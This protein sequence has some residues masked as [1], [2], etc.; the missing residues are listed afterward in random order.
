MPGWSHRP[1]FRNPTNMT[2]G[3]SVGMPKGIAGY[4]TGGIADEKASVA[5]DGSPRDFSRDLRP[6]D[7]SPQSAYENAIQSSAASFA[8]GGKDSLNR[9]ENKE[10][11]TLA[12]NISYGHNRDKQEVLQDLE[13]AIYQQSANMEPEQ[14]IMDM[15]REK[16]GGSMDKFN[17]LGNAEDINFSPTGMMHGGIARLQDGGMAPELF[18]DEGI[19]DT[20]SML[21]EMAASKS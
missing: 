16:M 11:D 5:Y 8:K 13:A 1:L 3:G 9:W 17:Q 20:S 14:G 12:M 6:D 2:H 21:N 19:V 7:I 18:E 10:L 4:E 15:I